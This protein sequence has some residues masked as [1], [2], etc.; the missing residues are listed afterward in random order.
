M[1]THKRPAKSSIVNDSIVNSVEPFIGGVELGE[2]EDEDLHL[3]DGAVAD[4]GGNA[5]AHA[6]LDADEL[7]VELHFRVGAAFEE[8]VGLSQ[9]LVVVD[10]GVLGD[11]GDVDGGGEIGNLGE[12]AA[13]GPTGAGDAG[14]VREVHDLVTRHDIMLTEE[15]L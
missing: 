15:R 11:V 7:V 14:D 3:A 10:G 12:G 9:V 8:V 1:K 2:G 5:D 4:A 6:G 13:S